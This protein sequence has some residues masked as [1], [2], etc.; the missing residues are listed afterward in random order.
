M[1]EEQTARGE[2]EKVA[3]SDLSISGGNKRNVQRTFVP[4]NCFQSKTCG[5]SWLLSPIVSKQSK[6]TRARSQQRRLAFGFVSLMIFTRHTRD[7]SLCISSMQ[8]TMR[9]E[10]S[11][12]QQLRLR[13]LLLVAKQKSYEKGFP[14]AWFLSKPGIK[15]WVPKVNNNGLPSDC[16]PPPQKATRGKRNLHCQLRPPYNSKARTAVKPKPRE[17]LIFPS[18]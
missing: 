5:W 13:L 1:I 10:Q 6:R 11:Q 17:K 16:H 9:K 4:I 14:I 18:Q 12:G 15:H 3:K 2:L 7:C 8:Y